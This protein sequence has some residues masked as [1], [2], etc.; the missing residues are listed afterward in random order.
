MRIISYNVNGLGAAIGKGFPDWLKNWS[1]RRDMP[2]GN[3]STKRK[4]QAI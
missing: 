1:S 4:I 3:K 2:A